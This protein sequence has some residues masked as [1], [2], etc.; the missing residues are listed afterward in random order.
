MLKDP[1]LEPSYTIDNL[2]ALKV[3]ADPLRNHIIEILVREPLPVKRIAQ[4]LGLLPN[5][6]YYH[7]NLLEQ[8]G[9]IR[10]VDT[11]LVSGIVEKHYRARAHHYLV[12]H[13][14]LSPS[15]SEGRETIHTVLATTIDSTRDDLLRSLQAR[16]FDLDRGAA[17]LPRRV[18][19]NR[20]LSR[21]TE[22]TAQ[23]F[24]QRLIQLT[25][26]FTAAEPPIESA[27]QPTQTYALMIAF[28]PSFYFSEGEPTDAT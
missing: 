28:Y 5:K 6:L 22:D 2:D 16:Y 25:E 12:D 9:L 1:T 17:E 26:E 4:L 14:L 15:T 8:H 23:R 7:V 20:E 27:D 24:L 3:L 21:L 19:I 13:S 10:V 11:R 18:M